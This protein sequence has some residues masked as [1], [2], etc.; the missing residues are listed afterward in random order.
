MS[1]AAGTRLGPYEIVAPIGAGGM[2]EVY[3]AKDTRL[4]RAGGGEGAVVASVGE[5]GGAAA[6]RAGGEDDLAV[7]APAHLL[8]VRRG[9]RGRDGL[10]GDGASRGREPRGPAGQGRA[11]DG[12]GPA[13]R[14]RDRGR[15][16]QGA[17][18]GDRAP[19]FEARQ[20]HADEDGRQ[21]ARLRPR[22][23]A[24]GRRRAAGVGRLGSRDGG[25]G[26]PASDRAG[27]GARHVPVHGAR[28]ARGRRGGR[29]VGHLRIRCRALR[30]GDRA[31]RRSR[32]RARRR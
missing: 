5:R 6:V 19:G 27:D 17:P 10:P 20:H 7:L 22:E 8:A 1:L 12:A 15:A 30:D 16:R 11:A 2:G 3:R 21:A 13:L 31:R 14:D 29:P 24:D 23:A 28:A 18:A 32:A 26:Q 25:A 9:P 4:D